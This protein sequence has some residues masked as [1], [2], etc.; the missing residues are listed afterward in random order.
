MLRLALLTTFHVIWAYVVYLF[1]FN[2]Q[3]YGQFVRTLCLLSDT[4]DV[5]LGSTTRL[6]DE[7]HLS[8]DL[9]REVAHWS[10][11]G[12]SVL[13]QHKIQSANTRACAPKCAS[14]AFDLCF[15]KHINLT[16][17]TLDRMASLSHTSSR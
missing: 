10:Q 11:C 9:R 7:G 13:D 2:F 8:D 5:H 4:M 17:T 6:H 16:T 3:V 14:T 12:A 1:A 15:D